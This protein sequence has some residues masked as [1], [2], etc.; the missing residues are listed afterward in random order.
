M[1][2][3]VTALTAHSDGD[4]LI[5]E[6][7]ED[8]PDSGE[9]LYV[10]LSGHALFEVDGEAQDAPTGTFVHVAP[11]ITRT[12]FAREAG[13]TVLAI[14]AGPAGRPYQPSGWELFAP[15]RPLFE[16]G[17]Y[18]QGADRAQTLIANDPPYG[19]LYYN[20]ACF[21]ARAGRIDAALG[22]LRRA[23]EL[24]PVLAES[25]RSDEDLA[26]L[27]DHATFAEVLAGRFS[28]ITRVWRGWTSPE[29]ADA[30]E[31]FLLTELFPAMERIPGFRGA[32][33]LRR[34]EDGDV[35]FVT[36]TRFET[37]EDVRAFAGDDYE[38]PVLEPTARALLSRYEPRAQH[39]DTRR[40]HRQGGAG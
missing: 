11:G 14:G 21:E 1:T 31:R 25:A 10:V 26:A 29:N 33:V 35:G 32:D 34:D 5:N 40:P 15:L 8:E 23:V 9:E 39:Y 17:D 36:L 28:G 24:S 16:A 38:T 20:I 37:L 6:H 3:G 12:A 19:V 22:H 2:F 30:Y 7:D 27:R 18:A 4:R 13:T